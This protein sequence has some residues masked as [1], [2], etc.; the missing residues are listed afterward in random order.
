MPGDDPHPWSV[1]GGDGD[2]EAYALSGSG[3]LYITPPTASASASAADEGEPREKWHSNIAFL[4]AA[5]GAAIGLGNVVRF[6]YLAFRFGGAAFLI[7]YVCSFF[8]IGL[9]ILGLELM[10]GQQM[11]KSAIQAFA[12]INPRAWGMGVLAVMGGCLILVYYQ[13][14]GDVGNYC[15]AEINHVHHRRR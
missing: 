14:R 15:R 10:L 2:G 8:V 3:P 4:F 5:I 13:V 12:M 11:Q 1:S 9:P 7:P 6:P